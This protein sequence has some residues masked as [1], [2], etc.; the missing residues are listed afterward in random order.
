VGAVQAAGEDEL[1]PRLDARL[2]V[3]AVDSDR[4]R[5]QETQVD[6]SSR[7]DHLDELDGGLYPELP[8]DPLD[9][10]P[11]RLVVGAA[12]DVKDL[13]PGLSQGFA[14]SIWQQAATCSALSAS[15]DCASSSIAS[16]R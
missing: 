11:R 6:R 1:V 13:D 15:T 9:Q 10:R 5:A 7:I 16:T 14:S 3:T 12:V 2:D 8:S 4:G